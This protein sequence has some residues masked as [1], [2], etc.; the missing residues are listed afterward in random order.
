MTV[1]LGAV[2]LRRG[3]RGDPAGH[4]QPGDGGDDDVP[5]LR[6]HDGRVPRMTVVVCDFPPRVYVT[7]SL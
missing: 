1:P 7:V 6:A 3:Q 5:A 4:G 2:Q